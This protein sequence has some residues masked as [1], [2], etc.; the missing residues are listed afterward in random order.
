MKPRAGSRIY[1]GVEVPEA[2]KIFKNKEGDEFYASST[3]DVVRLFNIDKKE[4]V[5]FELS[6]G[7]RILDKVFNFAINGKPL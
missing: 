2:S 7:L 4:F 3:G 5:T 1:K 6:L